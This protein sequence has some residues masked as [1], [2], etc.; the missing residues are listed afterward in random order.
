MVFLKDY[1]FSKGLLSTNPGKCLFMVF[2]FRAITT[3][4]ILRLQSWMSAMAMDAQDADENWGE[5][6]E[7][8]T[9]KVGPVISGYK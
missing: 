6:P 9:C 8:V 4:I 1:C 7:A 2:D 5:S 3:W